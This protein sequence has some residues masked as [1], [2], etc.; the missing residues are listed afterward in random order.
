MT[1][2]GILGAIGRQFKP[3]GAV[4]PHW[5]KKRLKMIQLF[6]QLWAPNWTIFKVNDVGG[7]VQFV[8]FQREN[9]YPWIRWQSKN[10]HK[11]FEKNRGKMQ[12][13]TLTIDVT[14]CFYDLADFS[15]QL[16][17]KCRY[18]AKKWPYNEALWYR[19]YLVTWPRHWGVPS[20]WVTSVLQFLAGCQIYYKINFTFSKR[21][22]STDP[23]T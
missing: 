11:Y 7:L 17:I 9:K 21:K 14:S 18:R 12:L 16:V 15:K 6:L 13:I 5:L 10:L 3:T 4:F 1:R 20:I 23:M 22:V 19:A 8:F 2:L